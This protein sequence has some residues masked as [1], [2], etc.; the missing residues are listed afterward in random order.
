MFIHA[1]LK[2]FLDLS[3]YLP[4]EQSGF[5]A[6]FN[7]S[8]ALAD[9]SDFVFLLWIALVM[10]DNSKAFAMINHEVLLAI[11]HYVRMKETGRSKLKLS[12]ICFAI[13]LKVF[14]SVD[15]FCL[16][17]ISGVLFVN[18]VRFGDSADD[19]NCFVL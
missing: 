7:C 16:Q 6:D 4:D 12:Y 17:H 5:R 18:F 8:A 9:V 3:R 14:Q 2:Q 13:K 1:K 10:L 15:Y 19:I 11:L